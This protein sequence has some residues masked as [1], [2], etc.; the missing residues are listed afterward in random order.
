MILELS[1]LFFTQGQANAQGA[2][3]TQDQF[4]KRELKLGSQTVQ[5]EIADD[6]YKRSLGLMNR[7]ELKDGKG[8][9]F[10]FEAEQPLS[11]WMKNT[12]IPLTVG[13][14]DKDK[15]LFQTIDMTPASPVEIRPKSYSSTRNGMY[16]LEVPHGWFVKHG[17][18]VGTSFSFVNSATRR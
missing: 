8:M 13:Y 1:I 14:F 5:V 15:K 10:I 17:I 3:P 9:L 18:K 12:L 7:T 6:N 4:V 2:S 16:A 11:F